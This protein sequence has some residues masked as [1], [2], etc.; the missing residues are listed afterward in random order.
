MT[1]AQLIEELKTLPQDDEVLAGEWVSPS[2]LGEA[3]VKVSPDY[4]SGGVPRVHIFA[5][6]PEIFEDGQ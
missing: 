3:V 4:C 2:Q 5:P 6:K 1:V